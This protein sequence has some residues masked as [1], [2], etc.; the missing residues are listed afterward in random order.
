M[1]I[2]PP[3]SILVQHGRKKGL[4]SAAPKLLAGIGIALWVA[5]S[6][7]LAAPSGTVIRNQASAAVGGQTYLSN[8]VE[9][10]VQ[11]VCVASV[12]PNGSVASPAQ[13]A[14]IPAG[15]LAYF[16]YLVGNTGNDRFKLE[17]SWAQASGWTPSAVTFYLDT[18]GNGRR[19]SGEPVVA[20][21]TLNA[22]ESQRVVLEVRA[23]LNVSGDTS[24]SPIATCP[25]GGQ[26]GDNYSRVTVGNGPALNVSKSVDVSLVNPDQEVTF[27][28]KV[29]NLGNAAA[30]GPIYLT[31]LL[32]T[33]ELAGFGF[34]ANS[35]SAPKG[36][37]EYTAN[38]TSWS[39]SA[40]PVQGVRLV[41]D[42]LQAGEEAL[43]SFRMLASGSAVAG[44]R[45]N[46]AKAEGQ[47]GPAVGQ[48]EFTVAA[49]YGV[50]LGPVGNPRATGA[51][52][53]QQ[54]SVMIG[55][56]YCFSQAL[57]NGG[58]TPDTYTLSAAGLP[59][60]V[61]LSY[62]TMSGTPLASPVALGPGERLDFK[63]C[64]SAIP[65][66]VVPFTFTL[67]A[68]STLSGASDPTTDKV[69]SV[70][71]P[72]LIVLRK[73][74]DVSG[75]VNPGQKVTYTL[76]FE[77]PLPM[78][79]TNV[80]VEDVLDSS[81]EFV[82]ASEGGTYDAASRTVRWNL[83]SVASG[84]VKD[85]SLATKVS[86]SAADGSSI[87]NR[88]SLRS[89]EIT[90]PLLSNPVGLEVTAS[91]LLLQKS[92]TPLKATVGDLLT[93]TLSVSSQGRTALTVSLTD[94]PSA[95]LVYVSGTATP[96]EPAAQNGQLVWS[97]LTL[98]AGQTLVLTYK[99]R[100]L[101]GAPKELKNVAQAVGT[102]S[103]GSAVASAQ[104]Q[105]QVTLQ[106]GVFA[107]A[108]LLLGR[109]FLD[110]DKDGKYTAGLDIPLPG[111]RVVLAN[112]W[113]A[114]TDG[115]GRYSFRDLAGGVWEVTLDPAS[116][117]FRPL[118][119][120]EATGNGYRHKVVVNSLT[121]SDFPLERPLGVG[122][123]S[124]ETVLEFGPLKV[125]KK[126]LLLPNGV[127]AVLT[128]SSAEP[129]SDLTVSDPLPG[130]GEKSFRFGRFQGEQ[131]LTYDLP[132]NSPLTDPQARWRYP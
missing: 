13:R 10:V 106:N 25:D 71:D 63:A 33:P 132:P 70:F 119:H 114:L 57:E 48:T 23:P 92:V 17:L 44:A 82:S 16:S 14:V 78:V 34:V 20:S 62:Q 97:N 73:S 59:S 91:V 118:P 124:R 36:R 35:A 9:T 3:V 54:A 27:N 43:L 128:V 76:H 105:A 19:D 74:A 87:V 81:L 94:T 120:P 61:T 72:S 126:L 2:A 12:T 21:L 127:L 24:V 15:G 111:A 75:S 110:T 41:L 67:K 52:D 40:T 18:N 55:Q 58:N 80:G 116:A 77:N 101:P 45:Q 39:A 103:S 11:A 93:Y 22:G 83:A 28:L 1:N 37:L 113:Q 65:A 129:L 68:T 53:V 117:P 95:G 104:A 85:L 121:E 38:G 42:S 51:A 130:G 96:S 107:P 88:F 50:F 102:N 115:E 86:E 79:L 6:L 109:V 64:L 29:A 7:A 122:K 56:P 8:E 49:R 98:N 69:V 84:S 66:A 5:F 108:N 123:V 100:V 4:V 99:M 125:S 31:D 131:T 90:N 89:S 26:D 32:N 60:G 112:G 46:V 30:G 47:G